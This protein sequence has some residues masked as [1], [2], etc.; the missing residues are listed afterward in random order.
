VLL[1]DRDN[2]P[3][4]IKRRLLGWGGPH[5]PDLQILTRDEA[6]DLQDTT[7]WATFPFGAYDL[8]I[9]DSIGAATE[10]ITETDTG[11]TGQGLAHLLDLARKGPAVLLLGNTVKSAAHYRGSG[12][13]A[14]RLDILYEVRDATDFTPGGKGAWWLELPEA[15]EAAWGTR[16]ARRKRRTDYR[17]A[18]IPSKFR[19][20]EEPEPWC[21]EIHLADP[22]WSLRDITAELVA[23]GDQAREHVARAT[24]EARHEAITA[25]AR[26]VTEQAAAGMP[27][28]TEAAETLLRASGMTRRAAREL[29]A[30]GRDRHWTLTAGAGPGHPVELRPLSH[31]VVG[32]N[33]P[34][35]E[36]LSRNGSEAPISATSPQSQRRNLDPVNTLPE[37]AVEDGISAADPNE[38]QKNWEEV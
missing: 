37:Q 35:L 23:A 18:L 31:T 32:G 19:I 34:T 8:V 4:E 15:G 36:P 1:L 11:A 16:A 9:L 14:D 17:L 20:G 28:L 26:R 24:A 5:A 7:A 13:W 10:R 2:S 22:P 3:R 38:T 27:L 30:E 6:P 21:V 25:L 12:I 29:I 33:A